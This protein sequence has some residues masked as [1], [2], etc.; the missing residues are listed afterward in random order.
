MERNPFLLAGEPCSEYDTGKLKIGDGVHNW[1]DLPY[2]G[3][4]KE[5]TMVFVST[6][7]QLPSVGDEKLLYKVAATKTL[8]QWNSTTL[9]YEAIGGSLDVDEIKL[10]NGGK[11]NG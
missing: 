2:V 11:S 10:I 5:G 7:D 3:E 6:F 9:E 4:N 8:Y 1:R